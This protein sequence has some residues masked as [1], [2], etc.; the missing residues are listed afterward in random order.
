MLSTE[1]KISK[2]E[3]LQEDSFFELV[4]KLLSKIGYTNIERTGIKI[5]ASAKGLISSHDHGFIYLPEKLSGNIEIDRILDI[6]QTGKEDLGTFTIYILSPFHISNGFRDHISGLINNIKIEFI[7]REEI[8]ELIEKHI[9]D[10]WKHDDIELLDYERNYCDL[11][12]KESELKKLKIFNEKYQ[13]LLDIF[14]EPKI[15]HYFEDKETKTPIRK[16]I[17]LENI[18]KDKDPIIL[19]GEAGTGKSTLLKRIGET[20]IRENQATEKKNLPIFIS[21]VDLYEANFIVQIVIEDKLKPFFKTELSDITNEYQI[22]LLIDSIDEFEIENQKGIAQQLNELCSEKG[23]KFILGT[24]STDKSI[25]I[26]EF[27]NYSSYSIARFNS[28]QINQFVNKF[29]INQ[30]SR[31]EKLMEALKENRI[32]EKLPIT[33]LS[34][35]LISI[36]FEEN[37]LEIPATITDI[38]DNFNSLL[39]GKAVVSSRIE[40]IDI[41][42]KERILSLYALELL[43]RKEHNPMTLT[44]FME[45]F[46]GYFSSKTLPIKKGTLEDVLTYLIENTGIIYLKNQKYVAFNHDSFMEYFAALEIFKHQ[47]DEE[48]YYVEQFFDIN[49]QNSAI[50]YAGKSKDMPKFLENINN[51]L[52]TAKNINDFFIGVNGAGYILQALYQTDNL[53]RKETLEIALDLN[54]KA[55]DLLMKLSADD[56]DLFKNFKLPILWL[57]NLMYFYENFNSITLKEP[58]RIGYREIL[59]KY[60]QNP[61]STIDGYKAL[62]IALTLSSKRINEMDELEELIYKSPL[63]NDSILTM[64]TDITFQ[65]MSGDS[66]QGVKK[67]V[68]K[69]FKKLAPE[70]KRILDIPASR[71][72]FTSFDQI[73]SKNRIKLITEGKTDAEI[74]EHAFMVLTNGEYPY[75]SIKPAGNESG[76]VKELFKALDSSNSTIT[77]D[78]IIIGIFDHDEFG[79]SNFNGLPKAFTPMKNNTVKKHKDSNIYAILL[80]IPGSMQHYL[81]KDQ[82]Y[83]YFEVEHYFPLEFLNELD[84]LQQTPILNV[85]SIKDKKK[86]EISQTIRKTT[87]PGFFKEFVHLFDEVD[88]IVGVK[89]EYLT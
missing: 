44:E 37:D 18:I 33:P 56:G 39:L 86:K 21:V 11:I 41:S 88:E 64:I 47:R 82:K 54:L 24:R 60:K 36:L 26:S 38:Y 30:Q 23:I 4:E 29:F 66:Y 43:K 65:A 3:S 57:M 83:N 13:K 69:E 73:K 32:I 46:Q 61:I 77:E 62:N 6:I 10:Y 71:L 2:I 19:S 72:R 53:I 22:T 28:Q 20:I 27:N 40:F 49:W 52:N 68:R 51:K 75:W 5:K 59:E 63:L 34:L 80:P 78:E 79:L 8:I 76:G 14:I 74:Y 70:A 35:S 55:H 81:N 84:A 1:K 9:P 48:I 31:A 7:G 85:F 25:L 16:S 50:F 89:I 15:V 67:E 42:F 17:T 58:L 45:F 12:L 87:T